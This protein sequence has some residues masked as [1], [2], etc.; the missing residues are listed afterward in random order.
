MIRLE[1]D[2]PY[3]TFFA[4]PFQARKFQST[5]QSYLVYLESQATKTTYAFIG[6]TPID[7]ERYTSFDI[8]T[9]NDDAL[10]GS[11]RLKES[12]FYN[13][14][15]YGQRGSTNLSPTAAVIT[16]ICERG[17]LQVIGADAWIIPTIVV[18]DNIVYYE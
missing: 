3:Q 16:G 14:T 17:L 2:T 18:P 9:S 12:G 15:I 7:N 10:N 11:I 5:I 4:S 8:N 13:V 1:P 6:N